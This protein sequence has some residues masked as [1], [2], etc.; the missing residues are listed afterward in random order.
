MAGLY[1]VTSTVNGCTSPSSVTIASISLSPVIPIVTQNANT[2]HSS[3]ATGN[4]W[5]NQNGIINGA[6]N[7][8]YTPIVSG[9]YY[10]IN[11]V[12]G[13]TSTS[14]TFNYSSLANDEFI[15]SNDIKIYPNPTHSKFKIDFGKQFNLI[16]SQIIIANTLGQHIYSSRI[17]QQII[18][19]QLSASASKGL[20][21]ISIFNSENK[22][23][24]TK[25]I[26]LN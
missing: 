9:N 7:Q 13:C 3:S 6:N 17:N 25:K 2:L 22:L 10:V 20:Y 4:Q 8:N 12:N 5:Y 19:I 21:F 16:G 1:S 24:A 18:E 15:S 26:L 14:P 23:I 11:T